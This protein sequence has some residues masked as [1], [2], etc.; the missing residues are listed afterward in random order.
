MMPT[1]R[2]GVPLPATFP[3][4]GWHSMPVFDVR[5]FVRSCLLGVLLA[6]CF[7][8]AWHAL[9]AASLPLGALSVIYVA[10]F[11]AVLIIVHE[12]LHVLG[13]PGGG[14]N[15]NTVIG[16][17]PQLGSPYVQYLLP[18]T[19]DRFI[20]VC[21]L[22]FLGLSVLPLALVACGVGPVAQLSW[23]SVLNCIGAGSDIFIVIKLIKIVP[24]T[25]QVME[26]DGKLYWPVR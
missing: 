13:F 5:N 15:A 12:G 2:I 6:V 22:P 1:L 7:G 18:M 16:I 20:L 8:L 23:L 9:V 3:D 26:S 10:W 19:R 25:A 21:L 14:A 24:A 17:W 4:A 11:A